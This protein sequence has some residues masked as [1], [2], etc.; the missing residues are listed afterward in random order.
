MSVAS[1]SRSSRLLHFA[2]SQLAAQISSGLFDTN[3]V[4]PP[5]PQELIDSIPMKRSAQTSELIPIL[6][7]ILNSNYMTGSNIVIDGGSLL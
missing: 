4:P 6:E 5:V 2:T 7:G 1:A 3:L